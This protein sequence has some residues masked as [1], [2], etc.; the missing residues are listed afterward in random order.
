[1]AHYSFHKDLKVGQA[2]EDEVRMVLEHYGFR[3]LESNHNASH[4][5]LMALGD[6]QMRIEVK[7]DLMSAKT[8]NIAVEYHS[9]GKP[10]DIAISKAPIWVFKYCNTRFRAVY[11]ST[12]L[13]AWR[14]PDFRH[15][16]GGDP[17]SQTRMFLVPVE[18]FETW[19]LPLRNVL[20]CQ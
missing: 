19:G 9:R 13:A 8:G 20:Q 6:R 15:V 2:A 5:L 12:L 14:S 16:V 10:S 4:D 18:T 1:M 7:T 17:G 11:L 3:Y